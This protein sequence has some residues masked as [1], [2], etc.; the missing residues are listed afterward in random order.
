MTKPKNQ[1][2]ELLY[3]LIKK[4]NVTTKSIQNDLFILNVTSGITYLRKYGCNIHCDYV[5]TKN[6]YGRPIK[7]G[8]FTLLNKDHAIKIYNQKNESNGK[9]KKRQSN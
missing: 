7:Y 3:Y 2:M 8:K 6:R 5:H 4:N 1:M 9:V